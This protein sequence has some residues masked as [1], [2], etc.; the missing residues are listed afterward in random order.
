MIFT[1]TDFGRYY[2][3]SSRMVKGQKVGAPEVGWVYV[4]D[5][6]SFEFPK[7]HTH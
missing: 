5:L 4:V 7:A 6:I 1:E 3:A 2:E